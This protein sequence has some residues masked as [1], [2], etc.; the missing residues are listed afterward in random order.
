MASSA[1]TQVS[2]PRSGP[3]GV[4]ADQPR[5]AAKLRRRPTVDLRGVPSRA[6]RALVG[7]LPWLAAGLAAAIPVISATV[8]AVRAGWV[9]AGDDGIIATRAWDVLTSHTPLIGQYSEAGL[10][11][12][13]QV[14]HSPGPMLYWLIALPARFGSASSIAVAMGV[15][16]TLSIIGCVALARRRGG[17]VLMFATAA[18][19]AVMC[20]SLPTDAMY[21]IWNP[22]AGLFPLL[23]LIFLSWSL[24]CGD[25]RLLPVTV[26]VASYLTQTHLM[27]L[28]PT[29]VLLAVGF[30]GLIIR[31]LH[32]RRTRAKQEPAPARQRTWPWAAAALLVAVLCWTAPAINQIDSNPGNLTMIVRTAQ[33]RGPELGSAVGWHAVVRAV[34]VTPWWLYKPATEWQRKK[35]VRGTPTRSETNTA[36]LMLLALAVAGLAGALR[37]RW[38]LTAAALIGLGLCGA[39]ALQAASNPSP[40][41]LAETLGYTLWWGSQL[42]FWVWLIVAWA[43]WLGL[44]Q[45]A[46]P[47]LRALRRRAGARTA[48]RR[49]RLAA[50]TFACLAALAGVIAA[51][52]AVARN[53]SP[54]PH[55]Y[56]YRPISALAAAIE[57]VIPPG[58]TVAYRFGSLDTATQPMEPGVRYLLI[59][60]GDRVLAEG[61]FP[62]LGS[63]YVLDHRRVQQMLYLTDS[64]RVQPHM[65]LAARVRFLGPWGPEVLSA[66]ASSPHHA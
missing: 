1:G 6:G 53:A 10:V 55:I 28:A 44:L 56:Q 36:I 20:Q 64:S 26:L 30:A 33:N 2:P 37:R 39:M 54:D 45:L 15:A 3:G 5:P 11:I 18:G 21:D 7:C 9:P 65:T 40:K 42:G 14:M 59:R 43:L 8:N 19:I 17:L 22:A 49:L 58:R 52:A 41:L 4:S 48:S 34:G 50:L 27:Y 16:N 23:L 66:W 62:R 32:R 38:D 12:H 24:A 25:H 31:S 61:S 29:A 63:Y 51:G 60:H 13:G 57:R 47:A 46:R 35:D